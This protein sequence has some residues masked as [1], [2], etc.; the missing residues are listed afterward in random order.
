[1]GMTV[2]RLLYFIGIFFAAMAGYFS[3][4]PWLAFAPLAAGCI[5]AA[6]Y[7]VDVDGKPPSPPRG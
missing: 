7:L 1:M 2:A 5:W 6:L 3:P 4:Y